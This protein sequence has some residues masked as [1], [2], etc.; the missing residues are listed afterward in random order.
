ML[1]RSGRNLDRQADPAEII[2]TPPQGPKSAVCTRLE[3]SPH[4]HIERYG[5]P[6]R[7]VLLKLDHRILGDLVTA[8]I[9]EINVAGQPGGTTNVAEI[10]IVREGLAGMELGTVGDGLRNHPAGEL[11]RRGGR[12]AHGGSWKTVE[13]GNRGGGRDGGRGCA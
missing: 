12:G 1:H 3:G 11:G 7:D 10:P 4:I 5:V 2:G 9:G 13:E 6:R 8:R